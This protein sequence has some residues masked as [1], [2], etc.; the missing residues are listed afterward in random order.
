MAKLR[1]HLVARACRVV[2]VDGRGGSGKSTFA[3]QLKEEWGDAV[4]VAMDDFYRP[5]PTVGLSPRC[6]AATSIAGASL[7]KHWLHF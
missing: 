1:N 4:I 2:A 7:A 3:R 6:P 5:S